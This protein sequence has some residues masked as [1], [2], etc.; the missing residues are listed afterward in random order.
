MFA[1]TIKKATFMKR[2]LPVSLAALAVLA[3]AT[4]QA[5]APGIAGNTFA[6]TAQP[7]LHEPGP[8]ELGLFLGLRGARHPPP[9]QRLCRHYQPQHP[10]R[11][12][13]TMQVPGPT[14]VVTEG[15]TV[16]VTLTNALPLRGQHVDPV[17]GALPLTSTCPAANQGLLTCEAAPGGTVTYTFVASPRPARR[18]YYSGTHGRL[19]RSRWACTGRSSFCRMLRRPMDPVRPTTPRPESTPR[20]LRWS[21]AVKTIS[22]FQPRGLLTT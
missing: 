17:S 5:A 13:N 1:T 3:S 16:S 7:A 20:A 14:L 6:L 11:F 21:P 10:L 8:M 19:C 9:R 4:A 15:Q 12:G 22:V 18:A 2:L